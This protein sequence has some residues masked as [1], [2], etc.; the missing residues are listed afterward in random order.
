MLKLLLPVIF[1]SWRF[2][3]SIGPSP[4]I[5]FAFLQNEGDEP[6]HWQAF[7]PLP[8]RVSLKQGL[9][10]LLWNPVWNETLYMHSCAE[11]LFDTYTEMREQEIMRR[12][13]AAVRTGEIT[14]PPDAKYLVYRICAVIREVQELTEPVMFMAKPVF[15]QSAT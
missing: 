5:Q 8:A 12:L 4:R 14:L 1:P 15:I 6:A 9:R 2:F 7:R 10:R 3:S 13:L 11:R